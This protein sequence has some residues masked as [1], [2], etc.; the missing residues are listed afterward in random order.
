MTRE[1]AR[2]ELDATT[3]RPQDASPEA[4]AL[5]ESD[6]QLAVWHAKRAEFDESVAEAFAAAIPAGLRESILQ[7]AKQPAKR[8][9]RWIAPTIVAAVAACIAFGFAMLWPVNGDMPAW[10][11][12]SLAAVVK[13]EHGMM[14]LDERAPTLDEVKKLLAATNSPSPQHLPGVIDQHGTFGCKRIQVA[15]RP[16]TI[17][18]FRLDGGKEAHL[19]V[20]DNSQLASAPPLKPQLQTNKNW[21]MASWS[22]G[23]QTFLLATSAGELELKK[24]LGL[25]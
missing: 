19:V 16:A 11:A 17:I 24:L 5:L 4:R 9:V 25:V 18:C 13:V 1:E 8:N 23:S 12:E 10:Q 15:G 3:L 21:H 6:S 14:K 2:L 22:E 7:N 20:M